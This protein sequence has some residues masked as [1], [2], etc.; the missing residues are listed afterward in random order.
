MSGRNEWPRGANDGPTKPV[1]SCSCGAMSTSR[2]TST[3]HPCRLAKSG[4]RPRR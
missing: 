1:Y 4:Q 2:L 3:N